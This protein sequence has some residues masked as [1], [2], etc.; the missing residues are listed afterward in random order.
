[1]KVR[2]KKILVVLVAALV[3]SICALPLTASAAEP[4]TIN[5][6]TWQ[7]LQSALQYAA[8]HPEEDVDIHVT[9]SYS[10]S[11]RITIPANVYF[12]IN[13]NVTFGANGGNNGIDNYGVM[14]I[15]GTLNHSN[16]I[17]NYGWAF[18]DGGKVTGNLNFLQ[19]NG[20]DY[21]DIRNKW[22]VIFEGYGG[23]FANGLS[24]IT[25]TVPKSPAQPV[26]QPTDPTNGCNSLVGWFTTS[27][28]STEWNFAS[29]ITENTTLYARW[30]PGA[31]TW[32]AGV[33]TTPAA[34]GVEGL[35]TF[36][37]TV[38]GETKTEPIPA[39]THN[40][41]AVV[42]APTCLD[43]GLT[44]HTCTLCG[45]S[46]TSAPVAA[47][48]HAWD[49]GVVTTPAAC[50]VEGL[51]TFTCTRCSATKTEA[52]PAL[53]HNYVA[54]VTAPTCLDAGFT[55]HTCTLCGNSYTDTP[56][57]ALGHA[58]VLAEH[59]DPTSTTDGYDKYVCS[60]CGE[61]RTDVIPKLGSPFTVDLK[62]AA[63]TNITS[64]VE[65]FLS[66]HDANNVL[67]LRTIVFEIDST[68]LAGKGVVGLNGWQPLSTVFWNSLGGNKWR[69]T[70]TLVYT[71]GGFGFTSEESV[72]IAKFVFFPMNYGYATMTLTSVEADGFVS[73]VVSIPVE[74]G[75]GAATTRIMA[76][77]SKYD[78]NKDGKV[79]ALDLG[80]IL[81]Y[82]GFDSDSPNWDTLV[83]VNDIHGDGVTASMCDFNQDGIIDML[84]LLD[85][86]VHYT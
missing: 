65:Y 77:Y 52:I 67:Q 27:T 64:E 31:H 40:Y 83:K 10:I 6:A 73:D 84:D 23:T 7:Q 63:V 11:G 33:V 44:T 12:F 21:E 34:C 60:R 26:P 79:D 37:C 53:T 54:V 13:S 66:V 43:A 70:V 59:K 71:G 8:Q 28:G 68:M 19:G 5:A 16:N 61:T 4:T 56:V 82:T 42:T 75:I 24:R 78:L 47:L 57:A 76:N 14:F 72:D 81:L 20:G 15:L 39:L 69:G 35:T 2:H 36:T 22:T 3:L 49:D 51:K 38:C 18:I 62:T 30:A 45:D 55:T 50:G 48:G 1:M 9:A 32:N 85:L 58:W 41:V 46:Y 25:V 29:N 86:F 74:I 17:R 80:I